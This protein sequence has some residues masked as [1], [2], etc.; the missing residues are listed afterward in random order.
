VTVNHQ[1]MG[2]EKPD[3][4]L[5][6]LLRLWREGKQGGRWMSSLQNPQTGERTGFASLDELFEFLRDQTGLQEKFNGN[7]D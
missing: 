5:S 3:E 7:Q 2:S 4:Y 6:F 1:I